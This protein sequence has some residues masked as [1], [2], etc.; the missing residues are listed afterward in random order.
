MSLHQTA[1][2]VE[3][4]DPAPG[5]DAVHLALVVQEV[6]HFGEQVRLAKSLVPTG[7]FIVHMVLC[8]EGPLIERN[9]RACRE[10]GV[11]IHEYRAWLN[12]RNVAVGLRTAAY[13]AWIRILSRFGLSKRKGP[14]AKAA[15]PAKP[16]RMRARLRSIAIPLM[17]V[18]VALRFVLR[19]PR[20]IA[21]WSGLRETRIYA[22][23]RRAYAGPRRMVSA[24]VASVK[25]WARRFSTPIMYFQRYFCFYRLLAERE[26]HL[27]VLPEDNVSHATGI[28]TKAARMRGLPSMV[29]PFA[30]SH[31][32]EFGEAFYDRPDHQL[33]RPLNRI[34]A[35]W[36]PQWAYV[37]RGR[38][39]LRLPGWEVLLNQFLGLAPPK[40]WAYNSGRT[41][42]IVIDSEET[43]HRYLEEGIDRSQLQLTGSLVD[44]DLSRH[45]ADCD[46][47]RRGLYDELGIKDDRP[48][49]VC[50]LPPNQFGSHPAAEF[51]GYDALVRGWLR[52][53]LAT[54]DFNVVVC[55]HPCIS[56]ERMLSLQRELKFHI[57]S[58]DT[59]RLV[60]L[61]DLYVASVSSTIR[62][63]IACGKPVINYD[64]YNYGYE[65]YERAPGV[66]ETKDYIEYRRSVSRFDQDVDWRKELIRLQK[67][68]SSRWGRLDGGAAQRIDDLITT[69]VGRPRR[70]ARPETEISTVRELAYG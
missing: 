36:F 66:I 34:V 4:S 47:K 35:R 28:F 59:A 38:P 61:C 43:C 21:R 44:D 41:Q 6:S 52:P 65:D 49:I 55:L 18:M 5:S 10:L 29:L 15:K 53:L 48:L 42:A 16:R 30:L 31:A 7:R 27:V 51:A 1:A 68:A 54:K 40:P 62:W 39:L 9:K 26:I 50:A 23:L 2:S 8:L 37:Y 25:A 60:P 70:V 13:H 63:A 20:T 33:D 45:A 46:D 24:G 67:K 22:I 56:R 11:T 57:S 32:R 17:A 19:T 3:R 69:L 14:R 58:W 64:V 12:W